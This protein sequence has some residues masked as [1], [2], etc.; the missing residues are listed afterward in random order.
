MYTYIHILI[1][2]CFSRF[3]SPG[4]KQKFIRNANFRCDKNRCN[5]PTEFDKSK[6][7]TDIHNNK[8]SE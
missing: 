5:E 2:L 7:L 3:R 6:N 8:L 1:L 4:A